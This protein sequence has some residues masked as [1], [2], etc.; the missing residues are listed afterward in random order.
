MQTVFEGCKKF[1]RN[2][3]NGEDRV[4]LDHHQVQYFRP[5]GK[6]ALDIIFSEILV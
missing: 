4:E 3:F 1:I 6:T 5:L 2:H